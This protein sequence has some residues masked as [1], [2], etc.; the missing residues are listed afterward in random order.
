[1]MTTTLFTEGWTFYREGS[2]PEQ[3]RLPHDAMIGEPRAAGG[4]TGNHGGYFPGGSYRYSRTWTVP[5]DAATREYRLFFEGIYGDTV[6]TV[7]GVEIARS[8]SGYRAFRAPLPDLAP[9]STVTIRVDVDNRRTPNSRWYTGSGIYRQVWLEALPQASFADDGIRLVTRSLGAEAIVDVE[10][11]LDGSTDGQVVRVSMAD[12]D[13]GTATTDLRVRG[14]VA[15]GQL[16]IP[17]PRAWSAESPHLYTAKLLLLD[18]D[19]V[20]DER[21]MRT[22]IRT[23]TVDAVHGLRVN[24]REVKLRGACVHHD[25]G[26]L[27]AATIPAAEHRRARI[28]KDNGFN[29]IRSA[30]NP[31]SRAFLDACDELGLYVMDELTDVW[32]GHKTPHD[33]ADRFGDLWRDDARAMV[34]EDRNRPSVI[35]Y[36]IGNEIA[37]TA[38][39]EGVQTA[40]RISSFIR[41]LDPTRPTTLAVNMLL[42]MMAARGKSPFQGEHYSAVPVA[43]PPKEKPT[44]TAANAAAASMGKI[45]Q[46]MSRLPA[47]DKVSRDVFATVDVAG[48]NYAFGR[49]RA[50]RRRYPRRVILGSESMPGDLPTIWKLVESVPGV[51]GDFMWTGWD[52]LGEAGIGVWSYGAEPGGINKPYPCLVA[53]PGA[54]DITGQPGAPALLAR[55]V[56]G[57]LDAPAIAVRPLQHAGKKANRTPWRVSDAVPSWA[58]RGMTGKAQIEV[59]SADD[60]VE[61]LIN[62]RSL[63]RKKTGAP[64]RFVTRFTTLYEPGELVAI[65]YRRGVETG[66]SSLRSAEPVALT[67]RAETDVLTGPDDLAHVWAE[68]ADEHGVVDFAAADE[69]TVTVSGPAS[70]AG[71]GSAAPAT[72]ETFVDDTHRTHHGRALAIV[73]ATGE[74]GEVTV[75][76]SSRRHGSATTVI[77]ALPPRAETVAAALAEGSAA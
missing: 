40:G 76:V 44:S 13:G 23:I 26:I 59:Y 8:T 33:T 43:E 77:Q 2:D 19:H 9:G 47:A 75:T 20:V 35:M 10:V 65:G 21:V 68:L 1:M 50:D 31:L 46:T 3:V 51:I 54:F 63:G 55:A 61:L 28:L 29:A 36:S 56:W 64:R 71:L 42:N 12:A 69:V 62:G 41:E 72:E 25:N 53:G 74:P 30:H 17:A 48:Y 67:L 22:G 6:V 39:A 11:A 5:A 37:E 7:D 14:G 16:V 58:W 38:D 66:R 45:M 32:Y 49:Y 70:L 18:G 73:R 27:G 60:E 52:Y 15:T 24:G 4:G 57:L 34:A